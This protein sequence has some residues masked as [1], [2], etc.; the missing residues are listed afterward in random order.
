VLSGNG[1][2]AMLDGEHVA[3][4]NAKFVTALLQGEDLSMEGY[5]DLLEKLAKEGK[6]PILFAKEDKLLGI[7]AV[8]DTIKEDTAEAVAELKNMGLHVVMLT[9]DN[10]VTAK[11]IAAQAGV[12]EVVAG[13]LPD[14]KEAVIQKLM[15][16]GK[17]AMVGDGINDAIALTEANIGMAIGT[18]TDV[19]IESADVILMKSSLMDSYKAIR[20]S[21][22]TLLN[23]KENLFWAFIYNIIMIPI[24][25]GIFSHFNFN[26]KP[27]YGAAAMSLSSVTV[28]V[29][30]LRLNLVN[31]AK[32]KKNNVKTIDL[33]NILNSSY[34]DNKELIIRVDGMMCENCVKHVEDACKKVNNVIDAKASLD[35]NNVVVT[36]KDDL[37][38]NDV[39]NN[40]IEAGYTA[41]EDK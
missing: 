8:A 4:G 30:A 6:T 38:K 9:G 22:K 7:M 13:V 40:I 39:I 37:N 34:N 26:M 14:G 27:W 12:D 16:Q 35:G 18:G 32:E 1:L 29:N 24:A 5:G 20:L 23:I 41:W 25:A 28:C 11:A 21:Q 17:V 2:K 3:G 33:N 10:E 31:I 19:A 36:Y 15:P